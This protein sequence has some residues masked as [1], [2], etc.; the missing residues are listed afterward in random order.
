M[1]T[2]VEC[3]RGRPPIRVRQGLTV[4]DR[5]VKSTLCW[6]GADGGEGEGAQHSRTS[7]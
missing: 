6:T 3:K 7:P 5:I 4:L 2:K 1:K